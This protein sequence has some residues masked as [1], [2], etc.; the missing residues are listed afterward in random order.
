MAIR[1]IAVCG[2]SWSATSVLDE[3]KGTHFSEILAKEL[4]A[5]LHNFAVGGVSNF[6]I[7]LQID[8]AIK[9]KPDLVIVTP[10]YPD[11]IELP[12]NMDSTKTEISLSDVYNPHIH[13][14]ETKPIKTNTINDLVEK[15][16]HSVKEYLSYYYQPLAKIATDRWIIRDGL[17]QLKNSGIKFL[18][19]PQLL[20]SDQFVAYPFLSSI[21]TEKNIIAND[22]CVF[23][24]RIT[25]NGSGFDAGYHTTTET[26]KRFAE[27]LQIL[28]KETII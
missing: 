18:V 21:T 9:I 10:T 11:R 22:T 27:S 20:W 6:V 13:F 17:T 26:Q 5:D 24:N 4:E 16:Y 14:N 25:P 28:I 1:S 7:R 15:N 19:Q 3:Y 2:C 12:T 23:H 8:E